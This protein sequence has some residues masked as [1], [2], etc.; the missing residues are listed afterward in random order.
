MKSTR[1]QAT[2]YERRAEDRQRSEVWKRDP[3]FGPLTEQAAKGE[4][5]TSEKWGR[6]VNGRRSR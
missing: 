3:V 6:L 2:D 1:T 5:M 4:A